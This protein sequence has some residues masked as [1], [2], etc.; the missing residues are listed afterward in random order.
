M[1][2]KKRKQDEQ[3]AALQEEWEKK[4]ESRIKEEEERQTRLNRTEIAIKDAERALQEK[5]QEKVQLSLE[6]DEKMAEMKRKLGFEVPSPL[7]QQSD[8]AAPTLEPDGGQY[9]TAR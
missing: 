4:K 1:A 5:V 3:R 8:T 2:A 9:D 7:T 6:F